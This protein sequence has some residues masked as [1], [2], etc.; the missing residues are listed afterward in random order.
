MRE[1]EKSCEKMEERRGGKGRGRVQEVLTVCIENKERS[2]H[3]ERV[4]RN[5]WLVSRRGT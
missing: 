1:K 4:P 5:K 3:T 2:L